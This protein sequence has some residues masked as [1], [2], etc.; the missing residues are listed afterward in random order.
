MP[1]GP[2]P[3]KDTFSE[4][5]ER[6]VQ[7]HHLSRWDRFVHG[8]LLPPPGASGPNWILGALA[9]AIALIV[10]IAGL[11]SLIL[12]RHLGSPAFAETFAAECEKILN[13]DSV[14]CP[15]ITWKGDEAFIAALEATGSDS[16]FFKSIRATGIRFEIPW[17]ARF[18]QKWHLPTITIRDLEIELRSGTATRQSA[19]HAPPH[20]FSSNPNALLLAG[21]GVSPDFH[22]LSF[23]E[24]IVAAANIRWGHNQ[25][26]KGSLVDASFKASLNDKRWL[27]NCSSGTFSQNWLRNIRLKS[28]EIDYQHPTILLKKGQATI[29]EN[30]TISLEGSVVTGDFPSPEITFD[31]TKVPLKAL[32]NPQT[33]TLIS[34]EI[35]GVLKMAGSMNKQKGI[36]IDGDVQVLNGV[37]RDLDLL[38]T[39]SAVYADSRFRRLFISNGIA[40]FSSQGNAF[41]F[42]DFSLTFGSFAEMKG[43]FVTK[44]PDYS[45]TGNFAFGVNPQDLASLPE[46]SRLVFDKHQMGKDWTVFPVNEPVGSLTKNFS[47]QLAGAAREFEAKR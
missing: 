38:A 19:S 39:L 22:Q 24:I 36:T 31:L 26:S 29:G 37:V 18:S 2:H 9:R 20:Y 5:H 23:D 11:Y 46:F 15:S 34:G 12:K 14:I 44:P 33:A 7:K 27:L 21:F 32:L 16:S 25:A 17:T 43:R 4:A 1:H 42:S 3:D 41:D 13:A 35:D 30:G 6:W 8:V 45:I 10:L 28:L 40:K 47:N